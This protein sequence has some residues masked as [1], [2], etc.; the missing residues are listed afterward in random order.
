[1]RID[2]ENVRQVT[3][4]DI[5][6]IVAVMCAAWPMPQYKLAQLCQ[7]FVPC[8]FHRRQRM[9]EARRFTGYA[10]FVE[11][12]MT[13][14]YWVVDGEEITTSFTLE[15]AIVFSMDEFY[16]G[17]LSEE[18]VE[19]IDDVRAYGIR[20]EDLRRLFATDLDFA[21]W[22]RVIHQNEYRRLHRSHKERL[23]LPARERYEEFR[24]QFPE[25]CR[26]VNLGYIAS[27][28]GITQSTLSRM[29]NN[30]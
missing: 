20:L 16:Y 29:R 1:M 15:G 13:R 23:T 9:V 17:R 3:P 14:S 2:G 25:V 12:G 19:A 7:L 5:P 28:L 30:I 10:F 27:Y 26:R 21:N 6:N 11:Q 18:N 24:K 22:G 8:Q 4:D